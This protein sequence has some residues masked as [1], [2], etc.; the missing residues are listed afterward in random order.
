M[1]K[2]S[3]FRVMDFFSS[4]SLKRN[5]KSSKKSNL[6]IDSAHRLCDSA[7][8]HHPFAVPDLDPDPGM[9]YTLTGN[10]RY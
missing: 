8:S 5:T 9:Y 4:L 2:C 7:V 10:E 3:F 1:F 6:D